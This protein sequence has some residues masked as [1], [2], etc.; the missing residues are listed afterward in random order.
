M[1]GHHYTLL[2]G[3]N[4]LA[5]KHISDAIELLQQEF[6][7]HRSS[8]EMITKAIDMPNDYPFVN[9]AVC[10]ETVLE[11]IQLIHKIKEMEKQLGRSDEKDHQG[12]I[13]IDIDVILCDK[14]VLHADYETKNYVKKLIE[15]VCV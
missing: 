15:E 13:P 3:S 14:K 6:G 5:H 4:Y 7:V 10:I 8:N 12:I 9:K 11:P 1:R 2:L